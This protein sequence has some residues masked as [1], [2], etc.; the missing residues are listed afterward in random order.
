MNKLLGL[1]LKRKDDRNPL[2]LVLEMGWASFLASA[3]VFNSAFA[4]RLGA[5]NTQV[6]LLTS[7]PALMAV[8]VSIPAGRFLQTRR[9]AKPWIL[10]ALTIYR[11]GYLLVA[12]LPWLGL[13]HFSLGTQV[14][15]V[16]VIFTIPAHFLTWASSRCWQRLPRRNAGP[17]SSPLA[18]SFI[19]L[20]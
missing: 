5:D 18:T 12:L 10:S 17:P 3:A 7:I 4:V 8:L 20:R 9:Q 13:T 2:Y 19:T 1:D 14:I 6:G 15:F 11:S 16:L